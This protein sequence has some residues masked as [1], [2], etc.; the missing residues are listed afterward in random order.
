MADVVQRS[1]ARK[2]RQKCKG[3]RSCS[4]AQ[5][6]EARLLLQ[7]HHAADGHH[8]QAVLEDR[9]GHEVTLR[10]HLRHSHH[11][12]GAQR[13][14]K[15]E[16]ADASVQR[17]RASSGQ[18]SQIWAWRG[19]IAGLQK[20]EAAV[21]A[22]EQARITVDRTVGRQLGSEG[23][24]R[25]RAA[26]VGSSTQVR[27]STTDPVVSRTPA[28]AGHP[29]RQVG[30]DEVMLTAVSAW[31]GEREITPQKPRWSSM[32]RSE[33]V[34]RMAMAASGN[35]SFPILP[36][37]AA[38]SVRQ[39]TSDAMMR[40]SRLGDCS[41]TSSTLLTPKGIPPPSSLREEP[42]SLGTSVSSSSVAPKPAGIWDGVG[43]TLRT[44]MMLDQQLTTAFQ[45]RPRHSLDDSDHDAMSDLQE[46]KS[47][48]LFSHHAA[49][50]DVRQR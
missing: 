2:P 4:W 41:R 20:Q 16:G 48:R 39:R 14:E 42:Q 30:R 50:T 6:K 24:S 38:F 8:H 43:T 10:S 44:A 9:T 31:L 29:S 37:T 15:H 11:A 17:G 34:Q 36:V 40:E 28:V 33:A 27:Q 13:R 32:V 26:T 7:E 45:T 49:V 47:D 25:E 12:H 19:L 22:A 5:K 35:P 3:T 1:C 21:G 23:S 18:R 46:V